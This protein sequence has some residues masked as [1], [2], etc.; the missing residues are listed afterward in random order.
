MAKIGKMRFQLLIVVVFLFLS[1]CTSLDYMGRWAFWG[2][3]DVEDYKKFPKRD[4]QRGSDVFHYEK[5]EIAKLFKTKKLDNHTI[6]FDS[7]DEFLEERETTSFIVIKDNKIIF[8]KYF[9][10]YNRDS[11]I[12]NYS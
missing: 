10:G 4:I 11:I 8:E 9:N 6:Q 5:H 7:F 12:R 3:S 1:S 2:S